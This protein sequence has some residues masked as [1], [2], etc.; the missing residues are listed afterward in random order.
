[1]SLHFIILYEIQEWSHASAVMRKDFPAEWQEI[2]YAFPHV[3]A[4]EDSRPQRANWR[5]KPLKT[6]IT[7]MGQHMGKRILTISTA[8]DFARL[9]DT[10]MHQTLAHHHAGLPDAVIQT[11]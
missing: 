1:M 5:T 3:S 6:R 10:K 9:G 7:L 2:V 11:K 4:S 8:T